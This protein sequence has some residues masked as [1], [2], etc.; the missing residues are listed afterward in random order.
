MWSHCGRSIEN[1][2]F[3]LVHKETRDCQFGR[4]YFKKRKRTSSRV[5][6]Q[7][8]RKVNCPA[9]IKIYEYKYYPKYAVLSCKK[10]RS[11]REEKLSALKSALSNNFIQLA[12]F[13]VLLKRCIL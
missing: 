7:G 8:T 11:L 1:S 9:H 3:Q 6:L 4:H 10:M 13:V 5:Y 2:P 12:L